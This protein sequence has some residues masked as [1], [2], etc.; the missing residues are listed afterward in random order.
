MDTKIQDVQGLIRRAQNS[1]PPV[2][3]L[4]NSHASVADTIAYENANASLTAVSLYCLGNKEKKNIHVWYR[5]TF[6]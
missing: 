2:L 3:M 1:V 4:P 6:P 5:Y